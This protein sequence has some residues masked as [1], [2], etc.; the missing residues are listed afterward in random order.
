M[1]GRAGAL[2]LVVGLLCACGGAAGAEPASGERLH[3]VTTMSVL[4]DL[5]E[6]AGGDAVRVSSLTPVG[7]DPHTHEPSPSDARR[8]A[9]ADLVVDNGLGL[10]PW[11]EPLADGAREPVLRLAEQ[12]EVP[13]LD[14]EDGTPDPHLWMVP[15]TAAAYV[16]AVAEELARLDPAGADEYLARAEAARD[17]LAALDAELRARIQTVPAEQRLLVTSHDA[18]GYFARHY[19]I[20]V[21]GSVVGASTEQEPSARSVAALVDVVRER[22]VPTLFLETTVNPALLQRVAADAGAELGEPLYGDSVGPPGSGA[23]D[24]DGMLR[25]TTEALVAGWSR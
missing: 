1:R 10:A 2:L 18:Y 8:I 9:D 6:R 4:A 20:E 7:G 16:G 23:E 14:E 21:V 17:D 5:V 15:P 3:V 24:Y 25:A 19:G 22:Q 12:V 13:V 11:F